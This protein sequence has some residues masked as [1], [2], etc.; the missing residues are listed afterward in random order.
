MVI[1]GAP[2]LADD[3]ITYGPAQSRR[4]RT[5]IK[6]DTSESNA[7]KFTPPGEP[8]STF[9]RILSVLPVLKNF[10]NPT[11]QITINPNNANDPEQ[12]IR[13]ESVHALLSNANE[14]GQLD[15]LNAQNPFYQKIVNSLTSPISAS[16]AGTSQEIPAYALSG[17]GSKVGMDAPATQGYINNLIKQFSKLDPKTAKALG[18]MQ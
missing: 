11:G 5:P 12:T 3:S 18:A 1:Q 9:E 13:H 16:P 2:S 10:V 15:Q 7:G 14:S 4:S 6:F 17:E 8:T